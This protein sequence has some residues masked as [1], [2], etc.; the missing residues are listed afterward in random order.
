[1][2]KLKQFLAII[3]SSFIVFSVIPLSETIAYAYSN[4]GSS[5]NYPIRK[6]STNGRGFLSY[7]KGL[8]LTV[9]R[10]TAVYSAKAGKVSKV[11][12]GC[13]NYN[14]ACGSG[15]DCAAC[16]CTAPK[17]Y[18]S[19][20]GYKAG[21]YCNNG[22]G[23]GVVIENDDG[24]F[25]FYGHMNSVSVKVGDKVTTKT[26]LG[27][28]GSSGC[29]TGAH[30]H[31]SVSDNNSFN[32]PYYNPFNYIFPGFKIYLTNNGENSVNPRFNVDFSWKDFEATKCQINFGTSASSLNKTSADNNI[33][34]P[35]CYYNLGSKFGS[36]AKGKTYYIKVSITKDGATFNSDVYSFVAGAGNKTFLD[37]S[38]T[39]GSSVTVSPDTPSNIKNTSATISAKLSRSALLQ[40]YGYVISKNKSDV[41]VN[42]TNSSNR[43]DTS[44]R[45]YV[46]N[47]SSET[48]KSIS[49]T[50]NKIF[51]KDLSANTTYYYKIF[52][53]TDG[54]WFQSSVG[55]FKTANIAPGSCKLS[56]SDANKNIGFGD[57][58][59]VNWSKSSNAGSYILKMYNGGNLV[60]TKENITGTTF[61]FPASCFENAGTYEVKLSAKN[62]V[63]T[64]EMPDAVTITVHNDV[65]AT[66][67]DS[68]SN[69]TI[70]TQSITY[71]H[72]ASAPVNP[73][74]YG[75][76]FMGWD[77]SYNNLTEDVTIT[78]V[79]EANE[80]TVKFVD[81]MTGKV[82]KTEKVKFNTSANA[83][84]VNAPSGY[85]FVG[86]DK[87][88]TSIQG[89]TTVSTVYKWYN[90]NYPLASTLDVDKDGYAD[91]V[92]NEDKNGYDVKVEVKN[93]TSDIVKGRLIVALKTE[94]GYQYAETESSAFSISAN[95]TKEITV[96]VPSEIL[97]YSVEVYTINDYESSGVLAAPVSG[98]IDN[99]SAWSDW[100]EYTGDVPVIEG[101]NGVTR[102]ET[103]TISTPTQY[104]YR[105]KETTSSYATSMNGWT[106]DGYALV[107]DD[108]NSKTIEYVKSWPAGF[109]KSNSLYTKYNKTPKTA[110]ET[111]TQKVVINTDK[112]TGKYIYW[113]WCRGRSLSDGP[114][115]STISNGVWANSDEKAT[116]KQFHAF[117]DKTLKSPTSDGSKICKYVNKSVCSD[118]YY[119]WYNP[120]EIRTQTYTT[121]KKLY[122]YYKWNNWTEWSE[123]DPRAT[124]LAGKTEGIDY[125]LE[126]IAGTSKNLYRYKTEDLTAT[127]ISVNSEQIKNIR[128]TVDAKF[129]GKEATVFVYK[130]TQPSDFTTE[131]VGVTTVGSDGSVV[132]NGVKLREALTTETGDFKVVASIEGNT[133]VIELQTFEAPKPEYTVTFYDYSEDGSATKVIYQTV[134]KQGGTVTAPSYELLSIPEGYKFARWNQSTV[135]VNDN[136]NVLP[137]I[138]AKEYVVVFVDWGSQEVSL[139]EARYG[140]IIEPPTAAKV[141]GK[142]V[143]WDMSNATPVVETLEDG[144][145]K[146]SYIVTQ[147]TVITTQYS[148][149]E[150]EVVF[151]KPTDDPE[152]AKNTMDEILKGEEPATEDIIKENVSYG[153][154][155]DPP[156]EYENAPE[157]I[158]YGWKNIDTGEFLTDTTATENAAY[159]PVYEFAYTTETPYADIKSGEYSDEQTVTLS[160]YTE[161]AVI[162]YTTDGSDPVSSETAIE[163]VAPVT[164]SKSCVLKFYATCLGMNDSVT[165]TEL[166]AI[167]N[168]SVYYYVFSVYS[169]IPYQEGLTYQA[170][171]RE[172]SRFDDSAL[173]NIEGYV[174]DGLFYDEEYT[175]EYL[176]DEEL[177]FEST[178][179]YAKYT[180]KKYKIEFL[181]YDGSSLSIQEV[182]Y[183]ASAIEPE[184]PARPG[185][186]FVGWTSDGYQ[187]VS[188][189]GTY[190]A[191]FVAE[192]E[193]AR[194]SFRRKS[195]SRAAGGEINLGSLI[196]IT[197]ASLDEASVSWSSS[198]PEIATVDYSGK[199]TLLKPGTVIITATVDSTG[200]SDEYTIKVTENVDTAL[201]LGAGSTLR[202]DSSGY[203]RE[204]KAGEN[205]VNA[206]KSHFVNYNPNTGE[207]FGDTYLVFSDINGAELADSALVGTGTTVKLVEISSGEEL[208]RRIFV[209][210]GDYDGDGK[211][212]ARDASRI[213]RFTVDKEEPNLY[214]NVAMDVNGDGYV[215]NRDASM[216]SRYLVG[217]EEI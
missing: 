134:V 151:I 140:E 77:K 201:V 90:D 167:N 166:Y 35:S 200:E 4:S 51:D 195:T 204:I 12:T 27:E 125:E 118:S 32:G 38:T 60:Y 206:I 18:M 154:H 71:G 149:K 131:Y 65:T 112:A 50:V 105:L 29:S 174:Y 103:D 128:G 91:A 84:S 92:R 213:Q 44:T 179:L 209:M 53:K 72:S 26:K 189:D 139:V 153:E 43:K 83:P 46:A 61:A 137:E 178:T 171:I 197:P 98:A 57:T 21:E 16:G 212:T 76:T 87:D 169:N 187:N 30:L 78:T 123:T 122:N 20:S 10:G 6:V 102:V 138:E 129:A 37:Y 100:T 148:D 194:I 163:Y 24:K 185:Y 210:T 88:F 11:Y 170:L 172:N 66:F 113:H 175:D 106:Q 19:G 97:A 59:T 164:I 173:E 89:D 82:Y 193:Y 152:E 205:T 133:G 75:Y 42:L 31:F 120:I 93:V 124:V 55:S 111:A 156:A 161:N 81:G 85:E 155:V 58:A 54:S 182:D 160:S 117:E 159:Y 188:S 157:Y 199:T 115:N 63:S 208:D 143:S 176:V 127:D 145:S 45:D 104:R 40:E 15:K 99:S 1:M 203:I 191:K 114:Y 47:K 183:A 8:D 94:S 14:G 192:R 135:N 196:K 181:N 74:Q 41:D 52:V 2:K 48:K 36:L 23:N 95:S 132:I 7:H 158:F 86:W 67:V 101:E 22:M 70:E 119:W 186:V 211:I 108:A 217:K 177:A 184:V 121:Y 146:T 207:C 136:L 109:D 68:I 110:S 49:M 62:E 33:R 9:D 73:S 17:K 198:N 180:P 5:Y 28:V 107:K 147:N 13:K 56:I 25:C 80:Y 39:Q 116:Y 214:Q 215:N 3:L 79:Y 202:L 126:T 34:T 165:V 162:W 130:Y 216:V 96:F 144:T 69:K 142:N 141:E 64:V 168:S 190:T 150:N